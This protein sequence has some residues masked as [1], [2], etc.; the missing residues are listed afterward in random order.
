MVALVPPQSCMTSPPVPGPPPARMG[1]ARWIHRVTLL[2]NG[3]VL[4]SGGEGA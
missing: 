4:V 1:S 2:S 3:K